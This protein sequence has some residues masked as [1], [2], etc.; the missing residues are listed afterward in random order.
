MAIN[1]TLSNLLIAVGLK[2]SEKAKIEGAIEQ[3]EERI[4]TFNDK[5]SAHIREIEDIEQRIRRIKEKCDASHGAVKA[6]YEAQL[7]SLMKE[8]HHTKEMRDLI[9]RN[10]DKEKLLLR[11]RKFE[12]EN[13]ENPTKASEIEEMI[14]IK[15]DIMSDLKDED[16]VAA[17]LES[18]EYEASS[19]ELDLN[20][21]EKSDETL[22]R[23]LNEILGVLDDKEKSSETEID[24]KQEIK[25]ENSL[26]EA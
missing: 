20:E 23:E 15:A 3:H 18:K 14:D 6:T 26:I 17:K 22:N 16:K 8:W 13:L 10:L 24:I 19:E 4:R 21:L 12:L 2:K 5:L 9:I 7:R 25:E 1:D 11:N